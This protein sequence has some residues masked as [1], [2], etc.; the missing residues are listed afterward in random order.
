MGFPGGSDGKDSSQNMEDL[1]SIPG[2]GRSPREGN[3]NLLQ[4][5]CLEHSM[6]RSLASHCP[7]GC[8]GSDTTE[9]LTQTHT[10]IHTKRKLKNLWQKKKKKKKKHYQNGFHISG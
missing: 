10:Y 7:W 5:C 6:D 3:G 8:K 1:G 2:L 9:Q 4:Y